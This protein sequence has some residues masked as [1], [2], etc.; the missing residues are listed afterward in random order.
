M[1]PSQNPNESHHRPRKSRLHGARLSSTHALL[2]SLFC[3]TTAVW[4]SLNTHD[5]SWFARS[6]AIVVVIGVLLTSSQIIENNRRLKKRRGY[7]DDNFHRDFADDL[8]HRSLD[9]H[10][11][12][13]EDLWVSGMHGLYLLISG[14]LIWGFGDLLGLIFG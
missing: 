5:W 10:P 7:S 1:I 11:L 14:T 9:K 4:H 12:S 8:K 2:L 6:G 13:E 3:I